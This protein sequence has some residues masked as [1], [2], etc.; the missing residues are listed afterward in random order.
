MPVTRRTFGTSGAGAFGTVQVLGVPAAIAKFKLVGSVAGRETGLIVY[1]SAFET[2]ALAR[3]T[4][5]VVSGHLQRGIQAVKLGT[6]SWAVSA[7]S[8]DGGAD[9][10]YAAY[11]EFGWSGL[12]G[13]HPYLRP[14]FAVQQGA[15]RVKLELLARR[16]E[17][18]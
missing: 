16:L 11:E 18:L 1:R 6:Y 14:A 12:P 5:H 17:A 8:V 13:G 7:S 2:A 15:V 3:S 9:K 10:E 4:V